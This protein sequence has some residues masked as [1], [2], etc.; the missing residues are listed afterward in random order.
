MLVVSLDSADDLLNTADV[1]FM[2]VGASL[3]CGVA[4]HGDY[5]PIGMGSHNCARG[6]YTFGHEVGHIFGTAHDKANAPELHRN[7]YGY[8]WLIK[9]K[10]QSQDEGYRTIMA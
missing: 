9:P 6:Y 3:A 4:Y 1:G 8:G 7:N 2:L 5:L 10:G